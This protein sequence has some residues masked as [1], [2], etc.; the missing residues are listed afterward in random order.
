M[1]RNLE[2]GIDNL[3]EDDL[4][5]CPIHH[6]KPVHKKASTQYWQGY[7][8]Y[9]PKCQKLF[10]L[11]YGKHQRGLYFHH[12]WKLA[13]ENS[14]SKSGSIFFWNSNAI[15]ATDEADPQ[16]VL[17]LDIIRIGYEGL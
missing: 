15:T 16:E 5:E 4:I 12:L 2:I 7:Q 3:T 9:C 6:Q 10:Y 1:H 11:L 14:G 13:Q 8:T 17:K